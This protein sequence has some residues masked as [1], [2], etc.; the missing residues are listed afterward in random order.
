MYFC[1]FSILPFIYTEKTIDPVLIPRQI[2]LSCF[3]LIILLILFYSGLKKNSKADFSFLRLLIPIMLFAFLL[4]NIIS[5]TQTTASTESIYV[6][7]KYSVEII[8]F[9]LTTYLLIQ[10]KID[11]SIL[12]KSVIVFCF[13]SVLIALYQVFTLNFTDDFRKNI[14]QITSSYGNKNLFSS[15]LFLSIPFTA[16]GLFLSKKWKIASIVLS[17]SIAA[18]LVFIQTRGVLIACIL[19][20]I[21]F[22][23]LQKDY[24]FSRKI[25]K[26][27]IPSIILLVMLGV[28]VLTKSPYLNNLTDSRSVSERMLIWSNSLH[29]AKDNFFLGVGSGNWQFYFPEYGLDKFANTALQNGYLTFQRPH[30]DLLWVLCETG[31]FGLIAYFTVFI[32]GIYYAFKLLKQSV[33]HEEKVI[34]S[35]NIAIITGYI[36][37]SFVDFPLERIEHQLVLYLIFSILTAGYYTQVKI[38]TPTFKLFKTSTL[39][40]VFF[41]FALFSL[42]VCLNRFSGESHT[43]KMYGFQNNSDWNQMIAEADKSTNFCYSTDPTSMPIKWYKGVAL[44]SQGNI[45]EA[46]SCFEQAN[47][48]HPYNIHI[49]NNL[50]SCYETTGNHKAA[51]ETYNKALAISTNFEEARL[52]LSA[53]YYNTKEYGKAFD[54]IDKVKVDN[55]CQEKDQTYLPAILYSRIEGFITNQKDPTSKKVLTDV[56]N[57]KEKTMHYYL[58]SKK[59]KISLEQSILNN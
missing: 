55:A 51:E 14:Y 16:G 46:E 56:L 34:Y 47:L 17:V 5:F 49:L 9:M 32:S 30:N 50:A 13:I 27:V 52:N 28:L 23:V 54:V 33:K 42:I 15:I 26:L 19:S 37:I 20:A 39:F 59:K 58:L 10:K 1:F 41:A 57:S 48:I 21:I 12:I 3:V 40:P 11:K 43:K 45:R 4:V 36:L 29:M 22:I 44:F 18:L 31:I 24:L 25:S 53:V 35:A 8:F 6:I 38:P 2:F 7:S